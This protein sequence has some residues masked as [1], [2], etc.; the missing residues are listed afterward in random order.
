[1]EPEKVSL[2]DEELR[3]MTDE[4]L[5]HKADR[6]FRKIYDLPRE[7]REGAAEGQA[8]PDE[9]REPSGR[10]TAALHTVAISDIDMKKG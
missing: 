5:H 7:P 10:P 8:K 3:A 6:L 1:M 4:K 9:S 2:T